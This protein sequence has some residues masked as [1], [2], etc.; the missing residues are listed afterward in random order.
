L[1]KPKD[2]AGSFEF[3]FSQ[4]QS[5]DAVKAEVTCSICMCPY[6][7]PTSVV[8]CLHTFCEPCIRV[9][10]S[11]AVVRK[12]PECRG[13]A[14]STTHNHKL[15]SLID[16]LAKDHPELRRTEEQIA[17]LERDAVEAERAA[18]DRRRAR[19]EDSGEDEEGSDDDRSDASDDDDDSDGDRAPAF[20]FGAVGAAFGRLVHP[21]PPLPMAFA[22][23]AA[24]AACAQCATP[25]PLDGFQCPPHG[26]HLVCKYCRSAFPDRPSLAKEL[27]QKCVLCHTA[28]CDLYLGGCKSPHGVGVL[29]PLKD[30]DDMTGL[31]TAL[32]SGNTI[33]QDI[34]AN[35]LI[36]KGIDIRKVYKDCMERLAAG[37][38]T[39]DVT[40][41]GELV[42]PDSSLC[43]PCAQRAFAALLVHYRRAIPRDRLPPAVGARPDCWYGTQ[44]HTQ[45][46]N[47]MHAHKYNHVCL[48]GKRK[49]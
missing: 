3:D 34:L 41:V 45:H 42:T 4:P 1:L 47:P 14:R 12:C 13:P 2:P 40:A 28:F 22:F 24:A 5:G 44:C 19:D 21:A 9:A 27:P 20:G 7:R 29:Q 15:Q 32:F 30:R 46:K 8:P 16:G 37:E 11:S 6:Y 26:R 36:S 23:G 33:E 38:W 18:A 49:E 43:R 39:L 10:L 35:Y 31:P 48:P 17:E 25:S